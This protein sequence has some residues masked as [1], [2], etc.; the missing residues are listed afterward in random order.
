MRRSLT[1]ELADGPRR[2]IAEGVTQLAGFGVAAISVVRDS[3]H[4]EVM[5]VAGNDEARDSSSAPA[6]RS[7][8]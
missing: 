7:P 8:G 4:I 5:A 2:L 6:R 3:Q 1:A